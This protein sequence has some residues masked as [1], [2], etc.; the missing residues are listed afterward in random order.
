MEKEAAA[1]PIPKETGHSPIVDDDCPVPSGESDESTACG[2]MQT[3]GCVTCK[4][5]GM[6]Y[7]EACVGAVG[8]EQ[9]MCGKCL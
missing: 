5:R 1:K 8:I 6:W 2:S 7:Y 3:C 9:Y 4:E